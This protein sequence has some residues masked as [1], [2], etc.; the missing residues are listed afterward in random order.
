[1][2]VSNEANQAHQ[3]TKL[4]PC[5]KPWAISLHGWLKRSLRKVPSTNATDVQWLSPLSPLS[6]VKIFKWTCET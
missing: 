3:P 4:A 2:C 6:H 1:M 5:E